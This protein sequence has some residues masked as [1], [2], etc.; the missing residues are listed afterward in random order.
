MRSDMIKKGLERTPHR[1]LLKG[2][3]VPQSQMEKPFIGVATSF[4]DLIPGHVGMRDLERYIEKGIHSGGGYAFFFGIPGVCDGI[5]MGHKGMHYSLPTRELIADMV[6][7]VA[8]AHRLD[9][10]VLLTNC[11]K[12]TPGMLMA[13]ARLDIPCIVVTA[14]PMMSGRGEAGRKYSF[15]TDTFE[16]MARYK[17]GVIDAQEL[18]VCEDN[19]CPGMGSCQGLFTANTMAILTETLG[20]SLPRCGTALAVSAL[21]R[22]IAFASGERIVD[23]VKDNVTPRSILTR[24]AFE[25]AIRVDLALGGSSNTVL[26]LLAIAH[27][28]EVELP[29]ETFDILAKETPQL[30]S[31]NPA[32]EHF[33][34]DLDTAG[35][36]AGVLMQL[37]DKIKD[38]PTVMGLTIKQLAASIANVDETVI[39]PLSNPVKKEGGIAILSGN[40]APKGAVVKQSGVSAAMMNFTGT[41]RCFDSEE[42]AMAAIME[43]KIVAGDCVV[44]RYEGPKGGPGMREMLAPTAAIMGLGLG[45]SVALITDGRFSGGTRGPCIGHISPEAAEGGPIALVEEGDRIELDIPGRRLQLL[46]DDETL[47]KRR[48]NWQAPAPKIRTGWLARYAKVVTSANTGAVT[49]AD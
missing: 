44:I 41:A 5:S 43:G 9:G 30:A 2:T 38:N 37:G 4:T 47:A 28:A 24:A 14:G 34:E 26:H 39:R 42:A 40:I 46:V 16:A 12:I 11:D 27:E 15:V 45:D 25:N 21:K 32:G 3:G 18:Q 48:R 36:V 33:M 7:S 29:L 6:E 23:L 19:A 13:A 20:M 35:G 31:M 1:A 8:E 10:L 22:R 17:A 49:S